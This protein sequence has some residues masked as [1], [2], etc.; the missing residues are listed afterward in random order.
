MGA[1]RSDLRRYS[2]KLRRISSKDAILGRG[3]GLLE[4][5][6]CVGGGGEGGW[7]L[8]EDLTSLKKDDEGESDGFGSSEV[9]VGVGVSVLLVLV[10]RK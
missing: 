8:S 3:L 10:E 6:C 5:N 4:L 1:G 9:G 7:F 2:A